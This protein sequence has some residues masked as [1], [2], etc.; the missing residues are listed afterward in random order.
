MRAALAPLNGSLLIQVRQKGEF[1]WRAKHPTI[2][3]AFAALVAADREL[4][5]IYLVG[6]PVRQLLSEIACGDTHFGGVK[7]EVPVD[8]YD[9]LIG[10]IQ[11][12]H[13]ESY[14]NRN[15]VNSFL[16]HRC[17]REFL[18]QFLE[19]SPGF[20]ERLQ[21]MSYFYAVTSIDV[22][23]KLHAVGLL[24]ED[25][26]LKHAAALRELAV[27]TPDDGFLNPNI[28]SFLKEDEVEGIVSDI[29]ENLLPNIDREVEIWKDN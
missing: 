20:A 1:G 10:P 2:L 7:V 3:D 26:R 9:G 8:R 5:D 18:K 16:G 6:T 29:R 13:A 12:F 19:R 27:Q 17:G 23:N 28:V 24:A 22:L 11:A 21:V 14:E 25:Q 15:A 4:M